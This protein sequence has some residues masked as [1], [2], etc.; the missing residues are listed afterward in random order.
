ML[1]RMRSWLD[2]EPWWL[3]PR[4]L[5]NWSS[6]PY[7]LAPHSLVC[8]PCAS[9]STSSSTNSSHTVYLSTPSLLSPSALASFPGPKNKSS[10]SNFKHQLCVYFCTAV[11][12]IQ[13]FSSYQT[14]RIS[15]GKSVCYCPST[16]LYANQLLLHCSHTGC[17][18]YETLALHGSG[19]R[20]L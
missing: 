14:S 12:S 2:G 5:S 6:A 16:S 10:R 4:V 7:L 11:A 15:S 1:M 17:D 13:Y 3:I 19:L 20:V 18:R 9:C 8:S